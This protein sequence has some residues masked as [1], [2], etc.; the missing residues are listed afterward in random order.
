MST[1]KAKV[2]SFFGDAASVE[3][4]QR[5]GREHHE[6]ARKC[7]VTLRE[8]LRYHQRERIRRSAQPRSQ[9]SIPGYTY[10]PATHRFH[11]DSDSKE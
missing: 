1:Q 7:G 8:L 3:Q 11:S 9:A 5:L 2:L 6:N 4:C 10:D